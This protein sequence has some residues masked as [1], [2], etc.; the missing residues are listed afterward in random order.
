MDILKPEQVVG[1]IHAVKKRNHLVCPEVSPY[2]PTGN[3]SRSTD[4]VF[5]KIVLVVLY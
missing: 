4:W 5:L 2:L 3:N 1:F